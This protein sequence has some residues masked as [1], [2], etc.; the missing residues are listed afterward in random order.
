MTRPTDETSASQDAERPTAGTAPPA[1]D[2]RAGESPHAPVTVSAASVPA[3]PGAA[4]ARPLVADLRDRLENLAEREGELRRRSAELAGLEQRLRQWERDL[5]QQEEELCRRCQASHGDAPLG[6]AEEGAAAA[7]PPAEQNGTIEQA[8]Q[9]LAERQAADGQQRAALR[10]SIAESLELIRRRRQEILDR[11]QAARA[12]L[13][14]RRLELTRR[15]RELDEQRAALEQREQAAAQ[16]AAEA[17]R[18]ASELEARAAA[19]EQERR[20]LAAAKRRLAEREA[21]LRRESLQLQADREHVRQEQATLL[22]RQAELDQRQ[23]AIQDRPAPPPSTEPTAP[24]AV[25]MPACPWRRGLI[26]CCL[27]GLVGA[28]LWLAVEQPRYRGLAELRIVGGR[29]AP[30]QTLSRHLQWLSAGDLAGCW[31][32]P[33]PL[34]AWRRAQS[35]RRLTLRADPERGVVELG[36]DTAEA[37]LARTLLPQAARAYAAYVAALPLERFEPPELLEWN[38]RKAALE[39]EL[40]RRE[41]RRREIEQ[42]LSELPGAG[43]RLAAQGAFDEALGQFRAAVARLGEQ[44]E[45]LAALQAQEVPR[46]VVSPEAYGQ[47]L[48]EDAVYQ[49]DLKEFR[50][51]AGQY[52]TALAVA[53]V[54][55]V[56]PLRELRQSVQALATSLTEQR[57]LQP[58]PAVRAVLEQ[59]LGE[60]QD[61]DGLLAEFAQTWERRRETIE[62]LDAAEQVVELMEQHAQA[63]GAARR[64]VEE[65]RRVRGEL[66]ARVGQLGVEGEMGTRALVVASVL[67][68]ELSRLGERVDALAEAATATDPA[69]NFQLD[70]HD[71]QVR[72][73]R[74]RL[75]ERQQLVR[76]MLQ[77]EADRAA[78]AE[79]EAQLERLR[80]ALRATEDERQAALETLVTSLE[81]LRELDALHDELRELS[82]ELRAEASAVERLQARLTELEA[83]RPVVQREQVELVAAGCEQTAGLHRLRHAGLAGA[84]GFA[85]SGLLMLLMFARLPVRERSAAH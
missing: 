61:F 49:E 57:E 11:Q 24:T 59:G 6:T 65:G 47:A 80:A 10:R 12:E 33:P 46:G 4:A 69:A 48:A 55:L 29:G 66:N 82:A 70:A 26:L 43:E 13:E 74:A 53:M 39:Q 9:G 1:S 51:E 54:L 21:E 8:L 30:E 56:D 42:R 52:R 83:Q 35:E 41:V 75:Q 27:T 78:G 17:E 73:L 81:R 25:R 19:A 77:A 37:E 38:D 85:A 63:T 16:R 71:R 3:L 72:N 32:G 60:I 18:L 36:L 64:L 62:R 34:D 28:M 68:G 7:G 45:E 31:E 15:Q 44:R 5:A 20:E 2:P 14:R 76:Q 58:P 79:F 40:A 84:A 22:A 23:S 50:S 67:R